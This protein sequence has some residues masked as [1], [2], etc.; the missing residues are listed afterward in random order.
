MPAEAEGVLA[1]NVL[2]PHFSQTPLPPSRSK[3]RRCE[4]IAS[5]S[6]FSFKNGG[7]SCLS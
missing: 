7:E 3:N 1:C 6:D 5:S 4:C 2:V